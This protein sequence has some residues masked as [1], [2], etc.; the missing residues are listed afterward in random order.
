MKKIKWII[1]SFL[2]FSLIACEEKRDEERDNVILNSFL[3]K[4]KNS[5]EALKD[6]LAHYNDTSLRLTKTVFGWHPSWLG[7]SYKYYHYDLLSSLAY[8]SCTIDKTDEDLIFYYLNGW[9]QERASDLIRLAHKKDCEVLLAVKFET[10]S[11]MN[12]VLKEEQDAVVA[13]LNSLVTSTQDADG[14]NL[15]ISIISDSNRLY[16]QEFVQKLATVL[17]KNNKK[18]TLTISATPHLNSV[19]FQNLDAYVESYIMQ[20]YN[21]H[22]IDSE[23]EGPVAPLYSGKKW[24]EKRN[25]NN[26][27]TDYLNRGIAKEKLVLALPYYGVLWEKDTATNVSMYVRAFRINEILAS[28]YYEQIQYDTISH[29]AFYEYYEDETQYICYFDDTK[30]LNYKYDWIKEKGLKGVGIWALGYDEG[31]EILWNLLKKDFTEQPEKKTL[32]EEEQTIL[33]DIKASLKKIISQKYSI[34]TAIVLFVFLLCLAIVGTFASWVIKQKIE[35]D[36]WFRYIFS[37]VILYLLYLACYGVIN[38]A[39]Y[40]TYDAIIY[41]RYI[42]LLSFLLLS[43]LFFLQKIRI[44]QD[45]P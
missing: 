36:S 20:G 43:T 33:A 38:A 18:L 27:V 26:S 14:I 40:E 22:Y 21:Y 19:D 1:I 34:I 42:Y 35:Y 12:Y 7:D 24:K 17:K 29:T 11:T 2:L 3:Q 9:D 23:D 39:F 31:Y 45:K 30:T 37:L 32:K 28:S 25:I 5:K 41:L 8:F 6:S 4:I 16:F 15:I 13:K 10:I 44:N